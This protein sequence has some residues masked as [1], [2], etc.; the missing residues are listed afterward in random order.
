MGDSDDKK[1][2]RIEIVIK[3]YEIFI[4]SNV[5]PHD[6]IT[7]NLIVIRNTYSVNKE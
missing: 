5:V 2:N 7:T 1:F 4:K 3:L 6:E